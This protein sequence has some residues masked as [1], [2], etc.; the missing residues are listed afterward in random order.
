VDKE[1]PPV[2]EK[3]AD[4]K[5]QHAALWKQASAKGLVNKDTVTAWSIKANDNDEAIEGK[6]ALLTSALE[7]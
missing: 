7:A 1:Y 2:S 4:L 5:K 6:I 3:S